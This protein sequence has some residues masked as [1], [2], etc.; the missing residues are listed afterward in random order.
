M[1]LLNFGHIHV[2][3]IYIPKSRMNVCYG[4]LAGSPITYINHLVGIAVY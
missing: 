3:Y 4:G 2:L 1:D